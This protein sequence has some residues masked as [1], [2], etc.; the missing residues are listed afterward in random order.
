MIY[1]LV[2]RARGDGMRE[3]LECWG[4]G[5]A[6]RFRLLPYEDIGRQTSFDRG[7]YIFA[8]LEA[9]T[10]AGIEL[11][12]DLDRALQRANLPVFNH[13]GRTLRR[14]ELLAEL[15][16]RGINAFRAV[17]AR[18]DVGAIRFPV[19]LRSERLHSGALSPLLHSS[20]EV[21]RALGEAL[22]KGHGIEDLLVVEFCDT[23]DA[24][25]NYRKY[26]AFVV[27]GEV[28]A[29]SLAI[30]PEWMLKHGSGDFTMEIAVEERDY[31]HGNPHVAALREVATIANVGY[32]RIDYGV[33]DGKIQVWEINLNPTIG[34]GLR[35]PSGRVPEE[36]Q[37]LRSETRREFY[38]RFAAA[39]ESIDPG[40]ASEPPVQ[41]R[42]DPRVASAPPVAVR[43]TTGL[44]RLRRVLEPVRP[45]VA[46]VARAAFPLLG[47]LARWGRG[48]EAR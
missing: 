8:A 2:P 41:V 11:A 9:L 1:H 24:A 37:P 4:R 25:R 47:R 45:I 13:P 19:F 42:F 27:G 38:R 36:L 33:R 12:A 20:R 10:P 35:P 23:A 5:V 3:Y 34:R 32:G 29:R 7:A 21:R 48:P 16:G 15:H 6:D 46:P 30:G 43:R 28:I 39:F 31:V 14:F 40:P 44:A 18:D 26:A 22:V 17:R